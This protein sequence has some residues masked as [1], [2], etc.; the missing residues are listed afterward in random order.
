MFV[1]GFV[2]ASFDGEPQKVVFLPTFCEEALLGA[3]C[4]PF[5]GG[6]SGLTFRG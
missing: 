6:R 2:L 4:L 1:A 5:L 3:L